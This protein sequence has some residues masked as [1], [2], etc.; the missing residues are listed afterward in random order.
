[1]G[2][3]LVNVTSFHPDFLEYQAVEAYCA[4]GRS[5][6][7]EQAHSHFNNYCM[8]WSAYLIATGQA[9][10]AEDLGIKEG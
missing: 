10:E 1:M 8:W 4:V 2:P 3:Q 7:L 6:E 9:T 5:W